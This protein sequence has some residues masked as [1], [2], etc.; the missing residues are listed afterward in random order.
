MLTFCSQVAKLFDRPSYVQPNTCTAN[1]GPI[2]IYLEFTEHISILHK[3]Y[4][5]S[6]ICA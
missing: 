3:L 5:I 4:V 2:H 1:V 6:L